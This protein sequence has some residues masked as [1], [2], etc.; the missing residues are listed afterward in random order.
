MTV[1]DMRQSEGV[2]DLSNFGYRADVKPQAP[3]EFEEVAQRYPVLNQAVDEVSAA[4]E[5]ERVLEGLAILGAADVKT[6]NHDLGVSLLA[7]HLAIIDCVPPRD[8]SLLIK[9]ALLHD[10][11]KVSLDRDILA[12]PEGTPAI[13]DRSSS[14]PEFRAIQAHP[15]AGFLTARELFADDVDVQERLVVPELVLTH[16]C[17]NQ[18]RKPY[19]SPDEMRRLAKEGLLDLDDL[20]NPKLIKL[21]EFLALADVYDAI[22][23][24]RPYTKEEGFENPARVLDVLLESHPSMSHL[25]Q[26]LLFGIHIERFA[27]LG[28]MLPSDTIIEK[29]ST[30]DTPEHVQT[31]FRI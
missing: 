5:D 23:A 2:V 12:P 10:I 21:A 31:I 30:L 14:N 16:H 28:W 18:A 8:R 1:V 11:G 20:T 25:I 19:P 15:G 13:T 26:E 24:R 27:P 9:G 29:T 6:R 7:A 3:R 22:T 4:M 17:H